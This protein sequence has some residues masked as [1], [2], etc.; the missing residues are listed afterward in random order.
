MTNVT[1]PSKVTAGAVKDRA[2]ALKASADRFAVLALV[3]YIGI[4]CLLVGSAH[5]QSLSGLRIG[6]PV[7]KTTSIGIEPAAKNR[8]G[9]FTVI[10]WVFPDENELSVTADTTTGRIVYIESDWGGRGAGSF[11]DYPGFLY[12]KTTLNEIR[13]RFG[14]NGIAFSERGPLVKIADGLIALNAY[15]VGM[16]V[17]TF[18]T[19]VGAKD[20]PTLANN[21]R[22][23]GAI[24]A[25]VSISLADPAYADTA[26]GKRIKDPKYQR[27]IW[28]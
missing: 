21:K 2:A 1:G 12:G 3:A 4:A 24:A 6:D 26:W 14:S 8:T 19:K 17:V 13:A 25:L 15:E 23:L 7:S 9:R 10:R 20:I 11:S 22:E 16:I 28:P 18:V 27:I 5:A